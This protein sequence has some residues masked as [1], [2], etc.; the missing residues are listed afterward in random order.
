[1]RGSMAQGASLTQ[2]LV[3][4]PKDSRELGCSRLFALSLPPIMSH[5][6]QG[7]SPAQS[8]TQVPGAGGVNSAFPVQMPEYNVEIL[9][10]ATRR[11]LTSI[12]METNL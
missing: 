1:M 11:V 6:L 3:K 8:R 2:G 10:D 9:C 7:M 12:P 4:H 5:A